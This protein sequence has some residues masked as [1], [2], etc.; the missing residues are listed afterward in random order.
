V[1][2]EVLVAEGVLAWSVSGVVRLRWEGGAGE[3]G[4]E[5]GNVG[6]SGRGM[7]FRSYVARTDGRIPDWKH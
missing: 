7:L 2:D 4:G 6:D 3:A 1:G 5:G